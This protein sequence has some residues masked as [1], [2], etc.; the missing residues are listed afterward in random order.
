MFRILVFV[1]AL[2]MAACQA[3][4][5]VEATPAPPLRVAVSSSLTWLEPDLADCASEAS[6]AVQR[7]D[8]S[9]SDPE[10][11][12]LRLGVPTEEDGYAAAL[13]E[14]RL[15]FIV[16]P[17]NPLKELTLASA[18]AIFSANE[19][20][21]PDQGEIHVWALPESNDASVALADAGFIVNGAGLA[22]TPESM[23]EVVAGDPAAIGYLPARWLNTGVRALEVDGLDAVPILAVSTQEPQGAA[24]ALL[25][26]LQKRI[27]E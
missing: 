15:V 13:G 12:S 1:L 3:S 4:P 24:R 2:L 16:H 21:L 19:K 7:A 23:L 8:E 25:V 5:A 20:N 14:E 27:G 10:V 18:Q 6:V 17:D 9:S 22:P 11:I 26:C